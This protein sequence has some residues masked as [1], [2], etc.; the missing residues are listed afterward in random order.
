MALET[1]RKYGG[2]T[3]RP[4]RNPTKE[5]WIHVGYV[6]RGD[7]CYIHSLHSIRR[8]A[9]ER[10]IEEEVNAG[11]SL[12]AICHKYQLTP[13]QVVDMQVRRG[14]LARQHTGSRSA[15]S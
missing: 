11:V 5:P 6:D 3:V 7:S 14:K 13:R 9:L 2:D 8:N 1:S 4:K 10:H 15:A 12:Q